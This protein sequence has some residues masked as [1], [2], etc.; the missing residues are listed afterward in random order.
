MIKYKFYDNKT[1]VDHLMNKPNGL[2]CVID[3]MSKRRKLHTAITESVGQTRSNFVK[4]ISDDEFSVSHYS[5]K[6]LYDARDFIEKN[7][8]FVPTEMIETLRRSA[9]ELPKLMFKNRLTKSGH[10]TM[11]FVEPDKKSDKK[12]ETSNKSKWGNMLAAEKEK[13]ARNPHKMNTISRGEY[14]QITKARTIAALFRT[15]SLELLRTL[16]S[17]HAGIFFIR[18][19]RG[20][21]DYRPRGFHPD[22]VRQQLRAMAIMD[23]AK[24]R[25]QGYP[26]RVLFADFIK[27]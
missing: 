21:L 25:Q 16:S 6:I 3:D 14:S 17:T 5:G 9:D 7:Q 26:Y 12:K 10:L 11:P 24:A 15:N 22:M 4:R 1:T 19:I 13:T 20:D 23:T 18:C 8:D 27:R 2:F